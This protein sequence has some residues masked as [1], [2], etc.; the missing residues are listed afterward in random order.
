MSRL[1]VLALVNTSLAL[2]VHSA[3]PPSPVR[4]DVLEYEYVGRHGFAPNCPVSIYCYRVLVPMALE[5]VPVDPE[6]RWRWYQA[7]AAA[8]AGSIVSLTT[9]GIARVPGPALIAAVLVQTSYGFSFTAYDP[10]TADPMVFVMAALIAWC[11]F[12]DRWGLAL[13][14]GI[15]GIFV[16]ETVALVSVT[17]ALAALT[18]SRPTWRGWCLSG[19]LVLLALLSYRWLMDTYWGWRVGANP[20]ADFRHGSWLALWWS[21]NP[22]LIRKIYLLFAPFGFGWLFAVLGYRES[23]AR[24]RHLSVAAI[25][26]FLALCYVQ[27]PE[28]ALANSFFVVV[29]LAALYLGRVS[30]PMGLAAAVTNGLVTAKV[31]TSTLWL[32]PSGMLLVPALLC[33]IWV[34]RTERATI[35]TSHV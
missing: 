2:L 13:L 14:A 34:L 16:K 19:V 20:A 22:F 24:L 17:C 23:D 15:V 10:Y 25:A 32:P 5:R 8:T 3:A 9:F 26:P 6:T 28:R 31:G 4:S 33:A 29:P 21:N 1:L 12:T 30:L 27:T 7:A 35:G 11:W 18:R